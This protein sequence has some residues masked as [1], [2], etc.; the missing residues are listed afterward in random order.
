MPISDGAG[1]IVAVGTSVTNW[2]PGDRVVIPFMP[3]WLEGPP[4]PEKTATALGGDV[5]GLLREF[6]AVRADAL[7]PIPAH[8]S[9]EEAATL[10]C[11]GVTAW[12]GL[13]AAANLQPGRT[14]LLQGTGG[15][16]LFGL[17]FGHMAGATIIL[18]SSSDEKLERARKLGAHHTI[19]YRTHPTWA[20]QVLELTGGCGVD[21]TL[22]VGGAD[23]LA[24][25]ISGHPPRRRSL[26]HRGP[27]RYRKPSQSWPH[28]APLHPAPR[29]LRRLTGNVRE[30]EPGHH[31]MRVA[32]NHR[33]RVFLR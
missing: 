22:E 33:S 13:F 24:P 4:T 26:R 20:K 1:E 17:Q 7:L 3:D 14:L 18:L 11:A 2:K 30:N 28:P 31:A 16:S 19:N 9:F 27:Q 25:N 6:A 23:T 12:H 29:Y 10:P 5:D 8:L 15:V 21:L 32:S